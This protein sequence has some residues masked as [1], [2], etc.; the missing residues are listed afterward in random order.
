MA[1]SR[2]K[3]NEV[4]AD[5]A[6]LL[7]SSK[8]TVLA[9][10]QGTPVK[11]LQQ[12]RRDAR[13]SGTQ[14]RVIKNRLFRLVLDNDQRFASADKDLLVGQLLYAFNAEDEVAPAQSLANF[15]KLE[16]QIEFVGALTADGQLLS[17]D[18]VKALAALPSK[19]QLRGMLVGTIAAPLSGFAN[20]LAGNVRGVLNVL[21]AR[22]E[23]LN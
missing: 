5:T 10:Y 12:L 9:K 8:L 14:V 4:V 19:D 18:D 21:N 7:A 15:A 11:S 2:E 6:S 20:V 22:S 16:P 3:K 23:Q 13:G 1:L 17:A